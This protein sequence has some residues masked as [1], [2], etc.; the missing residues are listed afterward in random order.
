MVHL[1]EAFGAGLLAGA[2]VVHRLLKSKLVAN[3]PAAIT[4]IEKL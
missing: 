4:A 3:L 1:A 2:A